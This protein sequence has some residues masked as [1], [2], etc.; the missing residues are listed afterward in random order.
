MRNAFGTLIVSPG[1]MPREERIG[2]LR[3]L[4]GRLQG[5][6][7]LD[8]QWLGACLGDWLQR[9]GRFEEHLGIKA[10]PGSRRTAQ[11]IILEERQD[12][13]LLQ[14]ACAMG[15]DAKALSVLRGDI[16]CPPRH[17]SLLE[18]ALRIDCPASRAAFCRA[19]QRAS[20]PRP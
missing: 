11:A 18:E 1:H 7:R 10:R 5:D 13:A 15:S 12:N 17:A 8:V 3:A 14:L 19:R 6:P 9:G 4:A 20:H 16:D 2:V